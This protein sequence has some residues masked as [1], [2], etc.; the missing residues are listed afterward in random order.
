M[1]P[2]K[3]NKYFTFSYE[4]AVV[5]L[6]IMGLGFTDLGRKLKVTPNAIYFAAK[7]PNESTEIALVLEGI[8]KQAK[9]KINDFFEN[10]A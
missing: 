7:R 8:I 3:V 6:R 1:R 4:Q 5:A 10:A 2:K 9:E